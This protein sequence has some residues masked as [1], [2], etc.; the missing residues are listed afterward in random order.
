M[1][2]LDDEVK[3]ENNVVNFTAHSE[4]TDT[5]D[6]DGMGNYGRF[7]RKIKRKK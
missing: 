2:K 4:N 7:P 6:Y 1:L 5:M 3:D